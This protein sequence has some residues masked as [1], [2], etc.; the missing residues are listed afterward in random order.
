MRKRSNTQKLE[1]NETCAYKNQSDESKNIYIAA[2]DNWTA[3]RAS[4]GFNTKHERLKQTVSTVEQINN[5]EQINSE[6]L[7][8]PKHLDGS[9]NYIVYIFINSDLIAK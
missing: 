1:V 5:N 6:V 8:K 9:T 4:R 3:S 2:R 7:S